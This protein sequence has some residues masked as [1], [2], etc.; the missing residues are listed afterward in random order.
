[1]P[2]L[3]AASIAKSLKERIDAGEWA[4]GS[5]MPPERELAAGFGVARNTI[6]RA[7]RL[8]GDTV[9]IS[10][11]V[12]RGTFFETNGQTSLAD[13]IARMEG[14]SPA[15]MMEIRQLL[16]PTAAAFAATNASAGELGRVAEAHRQASAATEMPD[17]EHWDAELHHRVFA[18]SRNELLREMHNVLRLLRN[19]T[20]WFEMKKRSFSEERRLRYCGEHQVLVDALFRR[21][22]DAARA[23]MHAH[24]RTVEGNM[25]GR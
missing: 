8:L 19:Q 22:P 3:V 23:A 12:G 18:C 24:L 5:K 17:F 21:D 6:R 2:R 13:V 15:D 25:L 11:E 14:A 20:P 1:M 16:E 4:D 10:R 9:P 7:I